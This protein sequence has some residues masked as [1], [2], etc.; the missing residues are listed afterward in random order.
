[1]KTL[2]K[3]QGNNTYYVVIVVVVVVFVVVV[4]VNIASD[5]QGNDTDLNRPKTITNSN[6]STCLKIVQAAN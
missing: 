6:F 5:Y 4:V 2:P 3:N 1:M